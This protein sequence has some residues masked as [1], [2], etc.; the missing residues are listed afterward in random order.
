ME[1]YKLVIRDNTYVSLYFEDKFICCHD[2]D[3]TYG[4][5]IVYD[6]EKRTKM[7]FYDIPVKM[8]RDFDGFRFRSLNGWH[9]FYS[10][11]VKTLIAKTR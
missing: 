3:T 11:E 8:P 7:D 6:I 9:S 1:G 4:E 2:N 10:N 5:D